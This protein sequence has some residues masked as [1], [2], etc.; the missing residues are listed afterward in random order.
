M[1]GDAGKGAGAIAQNQI[2]PG[3]NGVMGKGINIAALFANECF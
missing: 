2:G 1:Q 3:I